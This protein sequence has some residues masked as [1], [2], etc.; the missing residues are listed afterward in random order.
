MGERHIVHDPR[1]GGWKV[2]GSSTGATESHNAT[3]SDAIDEAC[4]ELQHSGGGEVL[5]HG[6]GGGVQDRRTVQP[7]H[8]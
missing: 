7:E 6:L 2:V 1:E 4:H 5:I 8:R 3:Q